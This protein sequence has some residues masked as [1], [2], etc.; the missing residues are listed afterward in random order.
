[1]KQD[2]DAIDDALEVSAEIIPTKDIQ[3]KPTRTSIKKSKEDT[4]EIQRDY[5]YSRAQL[6]SLV[7][8]GQEAVDGIL[9][10]ADQSQSARAYEVAGQLIKH[11]ADTADKLMDLQKKV[12]DIEEV[13][14]KNNTTNVTNN[15]L[16]VGSTA[17]LQKMLKQTIKDS[18]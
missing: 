12:K 1:M 7:E 6:Y 14:T 16:F 8:K 17:E 15:A 10:V 5:E 9:D 4:P 18:K 13:D 2:F 3:K 11:V